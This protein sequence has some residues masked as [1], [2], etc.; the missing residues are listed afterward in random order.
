M[1]Q[2]KPT[3]TYFHLHAKVDSIRMLLHKAGVDYNDERL[4]REEFEQRRDAG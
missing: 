1:A 2:G 3:L 4:T